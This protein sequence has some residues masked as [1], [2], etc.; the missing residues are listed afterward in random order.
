MFEGEEGGG[1]FF[2]VG[3]CV[4]GCV[5]G[6]GCSAAFGGAGCGFGGGG[7]GVVAWGVGLGLGIGLGLGV[8]G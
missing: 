6:F 2:V 1:V 7:W 3:W 4:V 5:G 8:E